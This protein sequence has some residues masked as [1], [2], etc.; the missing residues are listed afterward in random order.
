MLEASPNESDKKE[1]QNVQVSISALEKVQ[2]PELTATDI[3]V[4]LGATWL[5][6]DVVQDFVHELL[7]PS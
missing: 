4:R 5:P 6:P 3:D 1:L 2:P 7:T